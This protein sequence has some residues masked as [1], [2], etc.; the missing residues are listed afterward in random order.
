[1]TFYTYRAIPVKITDGDT[2]DLDLDLGFYSHIVRQRFRLYGINAPELHSTKA[3]ERALAIKARTRVMELL[4]L[5]SNVT[6]ES[7][8]ADTQQDKYGRWLAIIV[9]ADG[10]NVN[11]TLVA[12]GLA[13][14][15]FP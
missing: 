10:I 6:I 13:V 9:N 11:D 15:Y 2:V 14:P 12:E 4:P 7:F 8:K 3:K 1:M 5:G